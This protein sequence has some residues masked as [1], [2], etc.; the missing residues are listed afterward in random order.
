M[1]S[2]VGALE[3]KKKGTK[4]CKTGNKMMIWQC[5]DRAGCH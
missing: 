2:R 3:R 4:P 1:S 5:C